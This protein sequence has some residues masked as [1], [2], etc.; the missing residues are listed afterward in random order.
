MSIAIILASAAAVVN[1]LNS[2]AAGSPL[3][4]E[5]SLAEVRADAEAGKTVQ[6]FVYGITAKDDP[7]SKEYLE[8]ARPR[9]EKL[10]KDKDNAL[11]WY[12]LSVDQ[13]NY[14]YLQKAARRKNVQ[15]LNALGTMILTTAL[16]NPNM[17]DEMR[18]QALKDAFVAFNDA[19]KLKDPNGLYNLG[20]CYL[21]GYGCPVDTMMGI[22]CFRTAAEAGHPEA[23]NN[24]GGC[25]RDGVVVKQNLETAAKWFKK[26]S[27]LGN[28]FGQ[29]NYGLALQ[30]GDGVKKDEKAAFELFKLASAQG[31]PEA[32]NLL[33]MCYYRG[34]GVEKD[35]KVARAYFLKSADA[36]FLPADKNLKDME[37][38]QTKAEAKT[39]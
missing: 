37:E 31:S 13:Q 27:E 20:M 21:N 22:N 18:E 2:R 17:L 10:A 4:Y 24:I 14:E 7:K 12:L 38:E 26:S 25:F 8:K 9:I 33:G 23:I 39:E 28:R 16:E 19:A 6:M 36:G 15:A 34:R 1:L 29:L 30:N 11:A 35:D 32:D 3:V 5:R